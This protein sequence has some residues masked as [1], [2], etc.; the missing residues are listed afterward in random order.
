MAWPGAIG[1]AAPGHAIANAG[2]QGEQRTT[3][4]VGLTG[5]SDA[6]G[7]LGWQAALAVNLGGRLT[8]CS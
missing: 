3:R 8:D 5:Q 1:A 4:A 2:P 7:G 6:R